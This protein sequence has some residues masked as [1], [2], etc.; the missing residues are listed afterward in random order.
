MDKRTFSSLESYMLSCMK[1]AA[2]DKAH[3]YRVL[4]HALDIAKTENNVDYD[5]LICSCLLHDIGR[6]E[7]FETPS[8]CHATVGGEKA[9]CYLMDHNFN[10]QFALRVK[11]CIETHRY[12][13][14]NIPQTIEAKILF[15]ADKLDATGAMGI[16]RTLLYQG[17]VSEPLYTFLQDGSI[18]DGSRDVSAS[19]FREYKYKLEKIYSK[20]YTEQARKIG[21]ERKFAAESFYNNLLREVTE[22]YQNGQTELL[23]LLSEVNYEDLYNMRQHEV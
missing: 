4:Y 12:R 13:K 23:F 15:D 6:K 22:T 2:H 14:N 10:H 1:D 16:A 9:Y 8:L 3:I 20:F 5:V 21:M 11:H 7:Q 18:S 19:F 17:I